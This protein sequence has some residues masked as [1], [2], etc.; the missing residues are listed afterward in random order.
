MQTV[1]KNVPGQETVMW[2][3]DHEIALDIWSQMLKKL[4]YTVLQARYGYEAIEVFEKNMDKVSLVILDMQMPGM[5]GCEVYD[6]LKMIQPNIKTLLVSGCIQ[7][8]SI[9]QLSTRSFDGFIQKPFNVREL[10]EKIKMIL[11]K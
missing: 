3:D 5:D 11:G 6:R 7:E 10:S 9:E 1:S 2:V 8:S 4:G